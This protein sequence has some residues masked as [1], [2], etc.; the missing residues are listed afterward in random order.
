V[1]DAAPTAGA[2]AFDRSSSDDALERLADAIRRITSISIGRPIPDREIDAATGVLEGVASRLESAAPLEKRPRRQP[3]PTTDPR[4]LFPTSP[5]IGRSNPL[6]P[7]ARFWAAPGEDGTPELRGSV[8][9]GYQ[10][11]GPPTCVHG[12]VIAELFDEMLGSANIIANHPAMTG[13]LTIRYRRVTPLHVPLDLAAR[14][15]GTERRKVFTWGGLYLNGELTAEAEGIFIATHPGL[16]L[17]IV[18][19]NA[20][21]AGVP[22]IDEGFIELVGEAASD[23]SHE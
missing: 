10:Y 23:P 8:T 22:V 9:F 3:T 12:G 20:E 21:Q 7:P 4:Q 14:C 19:A 6:A 18:T 17:D 5:I 1:S 13:T 2:S 16:M 15:T 11:E